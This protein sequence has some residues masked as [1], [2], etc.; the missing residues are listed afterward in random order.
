MA[1]RVVKVGGRYRNGM[2]AAPIL[3]TREPS[4]RPEHYGGTVLGRKGDDPREEG[5]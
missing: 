1:V 5:G 3:D 4:S 2:P